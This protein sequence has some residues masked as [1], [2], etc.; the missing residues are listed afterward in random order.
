MATKL[1]SLYSVVN[2]TLLMFVCSGKVTEL[3]FVTFR[4][5]LDMLLECV[6]SAAKRVE[7]LLN[8]LNDNSISSDSP[9]RF[10]D[11]FTGL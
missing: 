3:F 8:R 4:F 9:I 10:E 6:S 11:H 1:V 2:L 7:E 5:E